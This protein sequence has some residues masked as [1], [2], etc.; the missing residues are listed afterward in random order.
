MNKFIL[1]AM[2]SSKYTQEELIANAEKAY[3][4]IANAVTLAANTHGDVDVD[5]VVYWVADA[6]AHADYWAAAYWIK[7]YFEI[8]GEDKQKYID[9]INKGNK[10]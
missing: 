7:R 8:T 3:V 1:I 5:V 6:A 9:E 4:D 10:Q 2:N